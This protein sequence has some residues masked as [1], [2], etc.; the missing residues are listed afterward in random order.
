MLRTLLAITA[1]FFAFT[2]IAS[3]QNKY[4]LRYYDKAQKLYHDKDYTNAKLYYDSAIKKHPTHAFAYYKRGLCVYAE[5]NL[6]DAFNDFNKSIS[7]DS[8]NA[9]AYNFRGDTKIRLK[10]TIGGLRDFDTSILIEPNN[11][12]YR[13]DRGMAFIDMDSTHRAL[14]DLMHAY[15]LDTAEYRAV[16]YI[17]VANYLIDELDS[18][19]KYFNKCNI[20]DSL[21]PGPFYCTAQVLLA[22]DSF[23]YAL[24][25][26]NT[27]I[28]L[29]DKSASYYVLRA[30]IY[31]LNENEEDDDMA[32]DDLNKA[33]TMGSEEAKDLLAKY[34]SEGDV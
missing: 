21:A 8:T 29:N 23:D 20:I 10:D 22:L 19:Y 11:Y 12:N 6:Q 24:S 30:K 31:M 3:A 18:A 1:F 16:F 2:N 7:L 9:D 13:V 17:G 34:F 26:I 5:E 14:I 25:K 32:K 28:S 33:I 15:N 4:F 27:A